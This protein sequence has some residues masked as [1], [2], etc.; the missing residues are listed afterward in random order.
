LSQT[1]TTDQLIKELEEALNGVKLNYD[2]KEKL[3]T[4]FDNITEKE[5]Q[6]KQIHLFLMDLADRT[7]SYAKRN[8]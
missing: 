6:N 3:R 8:V 1:K 5:E 2:D 7:K 4:I